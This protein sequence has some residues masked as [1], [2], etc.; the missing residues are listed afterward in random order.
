MGHLQGQG[1]RAQK[2]FTYLRN[3]IGTK[4]SLFITTLCYSLAA[5]S[6]S[7]HPPLNSQWLFPLVFSFVSKKLDS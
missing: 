4:Y 5:T 7:S 6:P 1:H 2:E 3:P